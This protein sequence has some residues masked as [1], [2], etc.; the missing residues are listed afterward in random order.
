[1]EACLVG[2]I[3]RVNIG[4]F[5]AEIRIETEINLLFANVYL[6][7][8]VRHMHWALECNKCVVVVVGGRRY[9]P[10]LLLAIFDGG[11]PFLPAIQHSQHP[12]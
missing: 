3:W 7:L 11:S 8:V 10:T 2:L 4:H 12:Q 9:R 5:Q 1:M 6:N